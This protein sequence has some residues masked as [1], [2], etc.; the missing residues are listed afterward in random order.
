[1]PEK[2]RSFWNGP[3]K[4]S[5][6]RQ[7]IRL[8]RAFG[9]EMCTENRELT[10]LMAHYRENREIKQKLLRS[11]RHSACSSDERLARVLAL[12]DKL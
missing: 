3:K 12:T 10:F 1:M 4:N 7:A 11:L 2:V 6:E 8:E 5:R 9:E